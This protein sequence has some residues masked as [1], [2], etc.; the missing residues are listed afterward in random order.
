MYCVLLV[1]P[2]FSQARDVIGI[3]AFDDVNTVVSNNEEPTP[4][5]CVENCET[6]GTATTRHDT[7][8]A[9]A[10]GCIHI[11]P[12]CTETVH[13]ELQFTTT[14][15]YQTDLLLLIVLLEQHLC[16]HSQALGMQCLFQ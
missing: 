7:C 3:M 11:S 1:L 8:R 5:Q 6:F 16:H 13:Y 14:G 15:Y 12:S 2:C 9:L 10:S 4:L